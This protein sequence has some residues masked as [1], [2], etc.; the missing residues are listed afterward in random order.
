MKNPVLAAIAIP[1]ILLSC[2][3]KDNNDTIAK[4]GDHELS[5]STLL[6]SLPAG[7]KGKDSLDWCNQWIAQWALEQLLLEDAEKIEE[8]A[9]FQQKVNQYENQ[10]RIQ[11]LKEK[12]VSEQFDPQS[13]KVKIEDADTSHAISAKES[14]IEMKKMEIW[15]NYQSQLINQAIQSG[16][17]KK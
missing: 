3:Q 2:S 8:P 16:K 14:A 12:I 6:Q 10:L 5:K 4:V 9:D 11:A 1:F 17:W 13:V 7:L 15:Q